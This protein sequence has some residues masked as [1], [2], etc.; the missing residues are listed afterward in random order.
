GQYFNIIKVFSLCFLYDKA[1]REMLGNK[2]CLYS[3]SSDSIFD[4]TGA[5]VSVRLMLQILDAIYSLVIVFLNKR[6]EHIGPQ[7]TKSKSHHIVVHQCVQ[8][9]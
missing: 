4:G 1:K 3:E 6:R 7:S 2:R 9:Q 8:G 5:L